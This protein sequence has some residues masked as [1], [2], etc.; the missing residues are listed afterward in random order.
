MKNKRNNGLRMTCVLLMLLTLVFVA[1]AMAY[2]DDDSTPAAGQEVIEA[3][4]TDA[5]AEKASAE[6]EEASAEAEE[7]SAAAVQ[8][9]AHVD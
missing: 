7:A 6:A 9:A 8:A 1:S 2:A 4:Q 5:E 3:P